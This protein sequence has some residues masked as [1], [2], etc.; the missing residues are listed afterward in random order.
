MSSDIQVVAAPNP[1]KTATIDYA[2]PQGQSVAEIVTAI[3]PDPI[4]ARYAHI[5]VDDQVCPPERWA[6][7][8]PAAGQLVTVRVVPHGGDG[9]N[10]LAVILSVALMVAAPQLGMMLSGKLG[11]GLVIGKAGLAVGTAVVGM[12]GALAINALVPPPAQTLGD[13]SGTGGSRTLSITGSRNSAGPYKVIP[14]VLGRHRITPYYGAQPYTELVGQDQ[15]LRML[16]V[17]GY[18]PLEL[19]DHRIGETDLYEYL[20]AGDD[21]EIRQGYD[22]DQP[23]T[24]FPGTVSSADVGAT[25]SFAAGW[26]TQT[27]LLNTDEIAIELLFPAGLVEFDSDGSRSDRT[28]QFEVE[29]AV[30]GSGTWLT[31][32]PNIYSEGKT[33]PA[34]RP[35]GKIWLDGV[36]TALV[37]TWLVYVNGTT[38]RIESRGS[39]FVTPAAPAGAYSICTFT[40][41]GYAQAITGLTDLRPAVLTATGTGNFAASVSGTYSEVL[42]IAAGSFAAVGGL[43]SVTAATASALRYGIT[44]PV[45][46]GQYDVRVKRVTADS[47]S[48][49]IFDEA[50]WAALKSIENVDPVALSG[51]AK[52]AL[53]IKATDQLNGVIDNYNVLA[54]SILPRW[55][56]TA[57]QDS[58]TSNPAAL[59]RDIF[60][61][62]AMKEPLADAR[63]DLTELQEWAEECDTNGYAYNAVIDYK[64]SPFEMAKNVCAIGRAAFAI[65][66]GLY[67]VVRDSP[68]MAARGV[69]QWLTPRNSW[70]VSGSK[71]FDDL[72]AVRVNYISAATGYRQEQIV[73]YRDG[74]TE[75]NAS[76]IDDLELIGITDHDQA[77]QQARYYLAVATLRPEMHS[78]TVDVEHLVCTRGDLI[79]VTDDVALHGLMAGRITALA[80]DGSSNVTTITLDESAVMEAGK[81]Y[82]VRIRY[83]DG[84]DLYRAVNT[85][86]GTQQTLAFAVAVAAAQAPDVGDLVMFGETEQETVE[87]I[88]HHIEMGDDLTATLF[89]VDAD[90]AVFTADSGTIPAYDPGISLPADPTLIAPAAPVVLGIRSD[91]PVADRQDDGTYATRIQLAL[92]AGSGGARA[93]QFE[94]HYRVTGSTTPWAALPPV[95]VA[96]GELYL[97]GVR[98]GVGYTLR[99]RAISAHNVPSDW[100]TVTHTVTGKAGTIPAVT[101]LVVANSTGD[102]LTFA[103]TS[104][105]VTWD[106]VPDANNAEVWLDTYKIEVL[107]KTTDA[108]LF[109]EY[110][111]AA[112]FDF[113]IEKNRAS[114]AGPHREFKVRVTAIDIFGR[115]SAPATIQPVKNQ[116]AAIALITQGAH[117]GQIEIEFY[118][119]TTD[120]A[121]AG[122]AVHISTS[123]GFTP[124]SSNLYCTLAPGVT[125][126]I[127]AGRP[128]G[129]YYAKV[130]AFDVFGQDS[131]N[132]SNQMTLVLAT[133][134]TTGNIN[135]YIG[136]EAVDTAYVSDEAITVNAASIGSVVAGDGD[137]QV[138]ADG[139]PSV[140]IVT[141]ASSDVIVRWSFEQGYSLG[142]RDW[143]VRIKR[144]STTLYTRSAMEF[145]SDFP[146]NFF[147]DAGLAAGTYTYY[148]EWL[149]DDSTISAKGS[150][151]VTAVMK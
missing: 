50:T 92:A 46:N 114:Y 83:A 117:L 15:Y 75:A 99:V 93:A 81:T 95:G 78:R 134:I 42:E 86:A 56:G 101:N 31:V 7:T 44:W 138:A 32:N 2:A 88:V 143:G 38:G 89:Y 122:Y 131:I 77:W 1:F 58:P 90:D 61:G 63:L 116:S 135:D 54:E 147:I 43:A 129:T 113:T 148:L 66:D 59:Y 151:S 19:S 47:T 13:L 82:A 17:I 60:Q 21:I 25:L 139:M 94:L 124:S 104:C 68:A 20:E 150:L 74:Y 128:A 105:Q 28:V 18:G 121:L 107:N 133:Q 146:S 73:V 41:S 62:S 76:R 53:R 85:V 39:R 22:D 130:G 80:L 119:G 79:R 125:S 55:D 123:S 144:G 33:F 140:T 64:T 71:S 87:K 70:G 137:W 49:Q 30:A 72:H 48:D 14:K 69:K 118:I 23:L 136:A 36:E 110:Q 115:V 149:G 103:D 8:Y 5:Y 6:T 96:A 37:E 120:R 10:P 40:L 29:Y 27:T 145:G 4:L 51:L 26:I 102:D 45:S 52:V 16:F 57:W 132:Y 11:L 98:A 91:E 97:P 67:S 106:Y 112:R 142:L 111:K 141:A 9:K 65:K 109:T 3:Q 84:G 100:V 35:P 34:F 127:F 126:F 24:I 12:A 108:V